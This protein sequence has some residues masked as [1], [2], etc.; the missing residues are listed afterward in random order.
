MSKLAKSLQVLDTGQ[1][2]VKSA[3]P[4]HYTNISSEWSTEQND[5]IYKKYTIGVNFQSTVYISDN[6]VQ[7]NDNT[8]YEAVKSTKKA[9]IEEIFGEFRAPMLNIMVALYDQ[10]VI[11]AKTLLAQL[12]MQIFHEGIDE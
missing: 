8:L 7:L 12:E 10:D 5:F 1:R 3:Y 4:Y 2:A 9:V 11:R 6:L